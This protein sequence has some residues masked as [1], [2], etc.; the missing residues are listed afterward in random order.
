MRMRTGIDHEPI[1]HEPERTYPDTK[2]T[3]L[4]VHHSVPVQVEIGQ[5]S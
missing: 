2:V 3:D 4:E 1:D 5:L